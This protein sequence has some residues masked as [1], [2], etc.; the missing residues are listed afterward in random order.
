MYQNGVMLR[1]RVYFA[2]RDGVAAAEVRT[3]SGATVSLA[4]L[5]ERPEREPARRLQGQARDRRRPGPAA[6]GLL[7]PPGDGHGE[8]TP[9]RPWWTACGDLGSESYI[10]TSRGVTGIWPMGSQILV[11]HNGSIEKIRGGIPPGTNIDSDMYLDPFTEQ[12]GCS[13]PSSIVG[14]QENV[15]WAASRG[16]Y[17]SDGSTI[18]SLT[19]QGGIAD[20]WRTLY[21]ASGAGRRSSARSSSTCSSSAS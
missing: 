14:W 5:H 1:D 9:V 4:Q 2:P 15:I 7:L 16:I 11:F 21:R 8:R 13:D 18:R 19:E 12:M 10:D 20:F 3:R 6:A 17:L